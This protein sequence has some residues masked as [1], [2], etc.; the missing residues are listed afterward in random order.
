VYDFLMSGLRRQG[1]LALGFFSW[2]R[3]CLPAQKTRE[4]KVKA[5]LMFHKPILPEVVCAT[6]LGASK[7]HPGAGVLA[8]D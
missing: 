5:A 6:G 3:Q 4:Y 8:A 2:C 7:A 1:S